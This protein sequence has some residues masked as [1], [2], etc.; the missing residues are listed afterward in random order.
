MVFYVAATQTV[1]VVDRVEV[2]SRTRE[3]ACV[4]EGRK[5]LLS[6]A[7]V[8]VLAVGASKT[9][10]TEAGVVDTMS[11]GDGKTS[12]LTMSLETIM[13]KVT[14]RS[15][16]GEVVLPLVEVGVCMNPP[17]WAATGLSWTAVTTCRER[18]SILLPVGDLHETGMAR[19]R[20]VGAHYPL[21]ASTVVAMHG[22]PTDPG[23]VRSVAPTLTGVPARR[24]TDLWIPPWAILVLAVTVVSRILVTIRCSGVAE[25]IAVVVSALLEVVVLLLEVRIDLLQIVN[26]L[27]RTRNTT[28][29]VSSHP[30]NASVLTWLLPLTTWLRPL[31]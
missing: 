8:G 4:G 7:H 26:S 10:L 25:V 5:V 12:R 22:V 2:W 27:I 19:R 29:S 31:L 1:L 15:A 6:E 20:E 17:G 13:A 23:K 11:F 21:M 16:A 28:R 30:L 14:Q 9:L 3:V 18:V 24:R